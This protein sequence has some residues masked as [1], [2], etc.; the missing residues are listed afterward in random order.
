[1]K[2]TFLFLAAVIS[3]N[4]LKSQ[5]I[6]P[7]T[8][9]EFI[10]AISKVDLSDK[11]DETSGLVWTETGIWTM[12]D[13]K[14]AASIYRLD[15]S[16]GAILQTVNI[17]N[18]SNTDW[19]DIADDSMYI[20]IG[21]VGNN[22]GVR[23][24]LK[25]LRI[26]KS[27]IGTQATQNIS[28][29]AI[30]FS[31]PDQKNFSPSSVS[32][33]NCEAMVAY[34]DHLYV[35]T[36]DHGDNKTR[37]YRIPKTPGTYSAE[38]IDSF[39]CKG[40]I[41]ASDVSPD[42]KQIALLGYAN[43]HTYS[44][45][46]ILSD[47]TGDHFCSGKKKKYVIGEFSDWQTEGLAYQDSV[48]IWVSNEVTTAYVQRLYHYTSSEILTKAGVE[49]SRI[50]GFKI[51]PNPA[52]SGFVTLQIPGNI[53]V[54]E[55]RVINSLGQKIRLPFVRTGTSCLLDLSVLKSGVYWLEVKT[56]D[57]GDVRIGELVNW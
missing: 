43:G 6:N 27:K 23:K 8:D 44:F 20:Y 24:D 56:K 1:M 31:Y 54:L 30:N 40:L 25:I 13:S 15:T 29:E 4:G 36:K 14:N 21:D 19:E 3:F 50:N 26:L 9:T 52:N 17:T 32:N 34:Q 12:N 37:L 48:N 16:T 2:K 7:Q 10:P 51:Y 5:T 47:F 39:D 57:G 28:A 53:S 45:I 46:W 18:Y 22:D 42:G 33:F 11:V 35:F 38:L 49:N 41:T 55:I